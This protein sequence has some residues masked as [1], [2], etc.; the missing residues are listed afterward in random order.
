MVEQR[1]YFKI[2]DCIEFFSPHHDNITTEVKKIYNED[3]EEV[4]VANHPMQI[5]YL[6]IDEKLYEN[7][8]GR[9]VI[10]HER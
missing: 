6:D 10:I 9:K 5:L 8:M 1:N 4:E 7:D 2:G 3:R